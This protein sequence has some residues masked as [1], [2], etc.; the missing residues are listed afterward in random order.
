MKASLIRL[1]L[2]AGLVTLAVAQPVAAQSS[3]KGDMTFGYQFLNMSAGGESQSLPAGWYVDLAG[4][5]TRDVAVVAQ[6][7]GSYKSMSESVAIG[8]VTIAAGERAGT[9]A[10]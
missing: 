2:G 10:G 7:G 9:F 8:G 3:E 4:N 5:L 6:V 1:A